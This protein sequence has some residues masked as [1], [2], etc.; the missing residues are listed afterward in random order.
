MVDPSLPG[1]KLRAELGRVAVIPG[2]TLYP[3]TYSLECSH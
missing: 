1:L 2:Q 3:C